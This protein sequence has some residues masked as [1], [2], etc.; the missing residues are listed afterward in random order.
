MQ[1]AFIKLFNQADP[2]L[3]I[4]LGV[5]FLLGLLV[6][7]LAAH[8]PAYRKN[9]KLVFSL[10]NNISN[11][12]KEKKAISERLTV[13]SARLNRT[14]EELE[15]SEANLKE[16]QEI[17]DQQKSKITII[18]NQ[19]ELYKDHA[20]NF[21]ESKEKLMEEY[22]SLTTMN[23]NLKEKAEELKSIIKDVEKEK[24]ILEEKSA[25]A[26]EALNDTQK[27]LKNN[28]GD[29]KTTN[30]PE[31]KL[32]NALKEIAELEKS[33]VNLE[34]NKETSERENQDLNN[35]ITLLKKQIKELEVE[36]SNLNAQLQQYPKEALEEQKK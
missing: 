31:G 12:S 26:I 13:T 35:Q 23:S 11:I 34:N 4:I 16:K 2:I 22:Q 28:T 33:I 17:T 21:K 14:K 9:K 30:K 1:E 8:L 29:P 20:R 25:K 5:S 36:R 7:A 10:E 3:Y 15:T 27:K 18:A 19:L 6:W 24:S 32:K